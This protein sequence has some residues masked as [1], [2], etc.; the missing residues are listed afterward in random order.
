MS[1]KKSAN[2]KNWVPKGMVYACA[3][4]TTFALLCSAAIVRSSAAGFEIFKIKI[5][6]VAFFQQ[7]FQFFKILV[8]YVVHRY[9]N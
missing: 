1:E 6:H 3:A 7:N 8:C 2:Y 4:I 5:S 9:G